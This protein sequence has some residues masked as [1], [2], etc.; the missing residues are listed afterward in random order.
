MEE[1]ILELLDNIYESY[2]DN[3]SKM[4]ELLIS[5]SPEIA[6]YANNL[7]EILKKYLSFDKMKT[8]E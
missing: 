7:T 6:P 3:I 1:K 8:I 4:T 5:I 2:D